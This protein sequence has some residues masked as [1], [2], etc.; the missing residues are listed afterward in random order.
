MR[1]S[2]AISAAVESTDHRQL[3]TSG[4]AA[5]IWQLES[6]KWP[7]CT[8]L[9]IPTYPE[10]ELEVAAR[11]TRKLESIY[12]GLICPINLGRVCSI[13]AHNLL[14]PARFCVAH[15]LQ[16]LLGEVTWIILVIVNQHLV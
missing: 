15:A 10:T 3:D 5:Q 13:E 7:H 2:H 6:G 12:L 4:F 1:S 14:P 16:M 11:P 8:K 9:E